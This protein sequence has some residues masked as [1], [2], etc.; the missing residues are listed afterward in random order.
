MAVFVPSDVITDPDLLSATVKLTAETRNAA[1]EIFIDTTP[2]GA[3]IGNERTIACVI[4]ASNSLKEAGLT[5]KCLY[6]FLKDRWKADAN[7]IKFPFPMQSFLYFSGNTY[8][9]TYMLPGVSV[10]V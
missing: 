10:V 8:K 4:D 6:S 7:L 1:D 9:N 3:S 5:L 2:S